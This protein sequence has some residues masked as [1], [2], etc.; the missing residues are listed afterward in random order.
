MTRCRWHRTLREFYNHELRP[1]WL[2]KASERLDPPLIDVYIEDGYRKGDL[3]GP[4]AEFI[5][6]EIRAIIAD[7]RME[8]LSIGVV[9]LLADK[10]ALFIWDRLTE[11]LGPDIIRRHQITCGD[12]RTFQGKERNIMFL[13]MVSAPN[14]VG[15]PLSRDT[16][17]QRFNVAASRAR[18][19][20][21]L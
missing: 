4:E 21:Y 12:A 19:R 20:M 18:D 17:S 15:A 9:S 2:P 14:N 11:E 3:N 10:Q 5:V 6:E 13:S 1:L 16:F 7:P 8:R